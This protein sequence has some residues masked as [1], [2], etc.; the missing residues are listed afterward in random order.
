MESKMRNPELGAIYTTKILGELLENWPS[1]TYLHCSAI[2]GIEFDEDSVFDSFEPQS[3]PKE[4]KV[5]SDL[6]IWL[7][8]EGFIRTEGPRGSVF[9]FGATEI[10]M[11]AMTA[12]NQVPDPI[13]P[14]SRRTLKDTLTDIAKDGSG[15]LADKI[16]D[17]AFFAF[18]TMLEKSVG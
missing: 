5:C 15:K 6:V 4:W 13:N 9:N 17:K 8:K 1:K 12:I 2:T 7:Q 11:A 18:V 16:M 14:D 3:F 10:T